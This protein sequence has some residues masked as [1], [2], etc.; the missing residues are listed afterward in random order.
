[1]AMDKEKLLNY[2][3][4][5]YLSRQEV[6]FKL[7]L[8]YS[9]DAFWP[10]LLARRKNRATLLPLYNASGMPIC[11]TGFQT[12]N[13]PI[14]TRFLPAIRFK[15]KSFARTISGLL[16]MDRSKVEAF[17]YDL[18][19]PGYIPPKK[20]QEEDITRSKPKQ[21]QT[22]GNGTTSFTMPGVSK[23]PSG[24]RYGTFKTYIWDEKKC[25]CG[26][27]RFLSQNAGKYVLKCSDKNCG[28]EEPVTEKMV[29]TYIEKYA[30]GRFI[31]KHDK[32]SIRAKMRDGKLVVQCDGFSTIN[33]ET[34]KKVIHV[35]RYD[36]ET[37]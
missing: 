18:D 23:K 25:K 36:L 10:E 29:N 17:D 5:H 31:C 26:N 22:N 37:I 14:K 15:G 27:R 16:E 21:V 1:M 3:Q 2:F 32:S 28:K 34:G 24:Y 4:D 12:E 7:P 9:I 8:N 11:K 6:L 19:I 30:A 13:G 20:K 33:P 35:H